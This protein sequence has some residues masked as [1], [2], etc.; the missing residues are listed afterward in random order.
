MDRLAAIA[1]DSARVAQIAAGP[2]ADVPVPSCPGWTIRDLV[3]HLGEVQRFWAENVR[4]ADP[5][6]PWQGDRDA[7]ATADLAGWMRTSTDRLV[8]ALRDADDTAAC[9]TWWGDPRTAGAVSRHQ[10]QEAAVHRWDAEAAT[11]TPQPLAP[12]VGDDGVAEFLEV[13]LGDVAS[14]LPGAVELVSSDTAGRWVVGAGSPSA[15][16]IA[17]A[18]D[19][20]L[21]LYGR[22]GVDQLEVT[23]APSAVTAL[24]AA[25]NTE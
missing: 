10:V 3:D 7:P 19:L 8:S 4:A 2:V 20:V 18:S 24:V 5:A 22:V 23:G 13:M 14:Q 17:T 6:A 25:A 9:W 15:T 12:E 16:V 21:L 1:A 11:G